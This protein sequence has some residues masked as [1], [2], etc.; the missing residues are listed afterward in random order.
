M[1]L[2]ERKPC[3]SIFKHSPGPQE[4]TYHTQLLDDSRPTLV[5]TAKLYLQVLGSTCLSILAFSKPNSQWTAL[6]RQATIARFSTP[7][8]LAFL[9]R[10]SSLQA[11]M[12]TVPL[13]DLSAPSLQELWHSPALD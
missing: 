4:A 2:L 3:L 12:R 5:L 9:R 1:D 13:F 6:A 8:V 11:A 10:T 7:I